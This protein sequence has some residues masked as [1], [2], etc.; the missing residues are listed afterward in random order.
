MSAIAETGAMLLNGQERASVKVGRSLPRLVLAT[1]ASVATW[2][3]VSVL[4][5]GAKAP[6]VLLTGGLLVRIQ[7]EEPIFSTIYGND[8]RASG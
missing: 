6:R 5:D 1:I 2:H 4:S 3:Q 7:P 8:V